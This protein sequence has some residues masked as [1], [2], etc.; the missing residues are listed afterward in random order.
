MERHD[1]GYPFGIGPSGQANQ[2]EYEAHVRQLVRQV[3]LTSPGER[4]DLPEFGC[5]VRKLIFAPHDPSLD[6]TTAMLVQ[7]ALKR[8]V[9]DQ[10]HVLSVR[11]VPVEETGDESQFIVEIGYLLKETQASASTQV[12]IL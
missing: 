10:I 8:W 9:G 6:A 5:G 11:A 12:R 7:Q 3:L 2:S 4:I 1:Y